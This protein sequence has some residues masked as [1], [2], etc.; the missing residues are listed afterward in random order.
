MKLSLDRQRQFILNRK[1]SPSD[2][3]KIFSADTP[4]IDVRAPIEF[5]EGS[6]PNSV[7]LPILNDSE[8]ALI[9]TTYKQK[10]Q[11]EAIDLGYKIVSGSIKEERVHAWS[12]YIKQYPQTIVYCFR[13]GK[14]SQITQQWL[15]EIGVNI[16]IIEGGYKAVRN[17]FL[18]K[19]SDFAVNRNFILITGP[20]GSGK[21]KFLVELAKSW[22]VID[23]ESIAHHRGSAFGGVNKTQPTQINF[24]NQLAVECLKIDHK[25]STENT[26]LIED[27]SRLIGTRSVP[28]SLFKKMR[29]SKVVWIDQDLSTRVQNIYTDYILNTA[30]GYSL[31]NSFRCAEE[32]EIITS[33]AKNVFLYYEKATQSIQKKLGG[34]RTQ[35]ILSDILFS[36]KLF[37]ENHDITSNIIWIE[38]LLSWY[39]DPIYL[40]NLQRRDIEILF[41]GSYQD[42]RDFLLTYAKKSKDFLA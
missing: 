5:K 29:E 41:K 28:E 42:S 13:G 23:L 38:K 40:G 24:E 30:I 10:G 12:N 26:I 20:T 3:E 25:Y 33:E 8:R 17:Y 27:E 39:Y 21:T 9:G 35:E 22:P 16:P 2:F 6:I 31:N 37:L 36:K 11:A 15:A 32:Q 14:R 19:V 1:I 18:K 34:L 7:N 4:L